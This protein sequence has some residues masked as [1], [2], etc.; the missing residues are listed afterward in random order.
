[1]KIVI[2]LE[3]NEDDHAYGVVGQ[4]NVDGKPLGLH[5]NSGAAKDAYIQSRWGD[6]PLRTEV[7]RVAAAL[8]R[9]LFT[10]DGVVQWHALRR[11]ERDAQV[12]G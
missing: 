3:T 10:G 2:T 1:M 5:A 9:D 8:L 6:Q 7:T 4:L 12:G 11:E